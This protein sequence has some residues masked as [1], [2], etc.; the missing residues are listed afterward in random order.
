MMSS[1]AEDKVF[2]VLCQF[3]TSVFNFNSIWSWIHIYSCK[4]TFLYFQNHS[5]NCCMFLNVSCCLTSPKSNSIIN[6]NNILVLI[7]KFFTDIS[8]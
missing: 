5:V 1:R 6:F 8:L 4:P 3:L 7:K 2:S